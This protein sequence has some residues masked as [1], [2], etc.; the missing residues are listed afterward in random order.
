MLQLT[1]RA[2]I[3][4]LLC[5]AALAA[6]PCGAA[7][8][9]HAFTLTPGVKLPGALQQA[10][11]RL[12][13]PPPGTLLTIEKAHDHPRPH[14]H[15]DFQKYL[16][17]DRRGGAI[18]SFVRM[19]VH[20]SSETALDVALR[21]DDGKVT[22]AVPIRPV[23]LAGAPV[24]DFDQV[25]GVFKESRARDYGHPLARLFHALDDLDR[26]AA[27]PDDRMLTPGEA[28]KLV[29]L[30]QAANP[31]R[32]ARSP[33]PAFDVEDETGARFTPVRLAGHA[34]L[35]VMA[36]LQSPVGREVLDRVHRYAADAPDRFAVF[37][38]ILNRKPAIAQYRQRGGTF[39][40]VVVSDAGLNVYRAFNP[41]LSPCI[42][43]YGADGAL[44]LELSP[45]FTNYEDMKAKLDAVR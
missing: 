29:A 14:D 5:A 18:G 33:V 27:Q 36:S 7:E 4:A 3:R 20:H 13:A 21:E 37:E 43:V 41:A 15:V 38:V 6:A 16:V 22:H 23:V 2:R 31:P 34:S 10:A 17:S 28:A 9:P 39:A 12:F 26:V 11:Y 25:L 1:G 19:R 42:Y 24:L 40:G 44:A 32:A 8:R 30:V 45:P 35:I